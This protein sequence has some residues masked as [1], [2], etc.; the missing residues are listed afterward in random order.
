MQFLDSLDTFSAGLLLH[1]LGCAAC[2][3]EAQALLSP[4]TFAKNAL[5]LRRDLASLDYTAVWKRIEERTR[6]AAASLQEERSKA[7]GRLRELLEKEPGERLRLVE[8]RKFRSWALADLLLAESRER[9]NEREELIRMALAIA[10]RLKTA[11]RELV[12]ELKA[13]AHLELADSLRVRG[14]VKGAEAELERTARLL[15]ESPDP[16]KR[17]GLCRALATLRRD[18]GR[19]D[20]ALALA[21]RAAALMED[22]GDSAGRAAALVDLGLLALGTAE[23]SEA[24]AAFDEALSIGASRLPSRWV[25]QAVRG[26]ALALA[27]DGRLEEALAALDDARSL[28]P[29]PAGS[30]E[31][32]SLDLL[33]GRIALEGQ[34]LPAAR[35][36]LTAAFYGFLQTAAP[37][38][39]ALSAVSLARVLVAQRAPRKAFRQL[40]QQLR[41]V[42]VSPRIEPKVA[43]ALAAFVDEA[44]RPGPVNASRL[45]ELAE[46][47]ERL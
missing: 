11:P 3:T 21:A 38:E 7:A 44:A 42:L 23:P 1:L 13:D 39:A 9:P 27:L 10:E 43:E 37:K 31:A 41:P 28:Y 20:E 25:L 30:P 34:L 5:A 32:L 2:A 16:L 17:A 26:T 6:E 24:L 15:A 4:S 40:A 29:W 47:L 22:G 19:P 45:K 36:R 12:T 8:T 33:E 46:R 18:Q 14:D 35:E